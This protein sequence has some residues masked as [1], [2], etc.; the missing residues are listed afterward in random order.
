MCNDKFLESSAH[1][2]ATEYIQNQI[3]DIASVNGNALVR[4]LPI[5]ED[6]LKT[7]KEK[8]IEANRFLQSFPGIHLSEKLP[9]L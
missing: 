3:K 6:N 5:T 8:N 2:F 4:V 1:N 9:F 7:V